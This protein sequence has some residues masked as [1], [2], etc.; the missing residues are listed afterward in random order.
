[1]K[2]HRKSV[3]STVNALQLQRPEVIFIRVKGIKHLFHSDYTR[4][5][6]TY[7]ALNLQLYQRLTSVFNTLITLLCLSLTVQCLFYRVIS[8]ISF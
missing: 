7:V 5:Y 3:F 8:R 4:T 1:M 2:I 6:S